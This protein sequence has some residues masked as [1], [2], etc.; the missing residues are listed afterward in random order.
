M[1]IFRKLIITIFTTLLKKFNK[2]SAYEK[3]RGA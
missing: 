3:K 1:I 2:K